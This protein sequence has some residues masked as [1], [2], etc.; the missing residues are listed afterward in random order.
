MLFEVFGEFVW[1][2]FVVCIEFIETKLAVDVGCSLVESVMTF[3]DNDCGDD[4]EEEDEDWD[5]DE[6]N[7]EVEYMKLDPFVLFVL[8]VLF[9]L[10][11]FFIWYA[12]GEREED[13]DD[14]EDVVDDVVAVVVP[15]S[16]G[17]IIF[18]FRFFI[19]FIGWK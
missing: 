6:G 8:G 19:L 17:C 5:D 10:T 1:L 12:C 4:D 7:D 3:V 15:F 18:S 14:D 13:G 9:S 2:E 16:N 11:G